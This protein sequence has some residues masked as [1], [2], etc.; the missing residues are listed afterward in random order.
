MYCGRYLRFNVTKQAYISVFTAFIDS[1]A[2]KI[3]HSQYCPDMLRLKKKNKNN[4]K[5]Q[6]VNSRVTVTRARE[7]TY[8]NVINC[9]H[10]RH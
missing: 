10:I 8:C 7:F 9:S 3:T 2:F 4:V 5:Y 1:S 6:L